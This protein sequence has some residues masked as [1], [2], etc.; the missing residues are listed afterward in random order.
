MLQILKNILLLSKNNEIDKLDEF[1]N[2]L[3]HNYCAWNYDL[4][5]ISLLLENGADI[6]KKN[7]KN[8][9]KI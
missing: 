6:N 7:N 2:T 4:R 9:I 1:G 3:L 8:L 5:L